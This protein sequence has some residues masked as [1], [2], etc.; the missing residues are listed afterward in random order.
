ML[1]KLNLL[2]L[3]FQ[4]ELQ[5]FKRKIKNKMRHAKA[6]TQRSRATSCSRDA[7]LRTAHTEREREKTYTK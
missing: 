2:Q 1:W 7:D 5:S 4:I 6:I 3:E